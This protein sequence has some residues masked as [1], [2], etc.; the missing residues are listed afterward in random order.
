MFLIIIISSLYFSNI[1][2]KNCKED[3][4]CFDNALKRCSGAV[5]TSVSNGNIY[6][7][8]SYSSFRED[9]KLKITMAKAAPGSELALRASLEGKSMTCTIK[10]SRLQEQSFSDMDDLAEFCTGPLK[11]AMYE[12]IVQ[13][14]YALVISNLGNI[15]LEA[16]KVAAGV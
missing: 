7:Y 1:L 12:M 2:K 14:M 16:R 15:S 11:E 10:R 8:E 6:I 3:K 9:C 5:L 13:R 4:A